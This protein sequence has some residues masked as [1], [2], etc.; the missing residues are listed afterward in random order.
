M[1]MQKSPPRTLLV[2]GIVNAKL[3]SGHISN[4]IENLT[5]KEEIW[6]MISRLGAIFMVHGKT[7]M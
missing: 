4:I 7:R 1:L 2:D 5:N 6:E 3:R